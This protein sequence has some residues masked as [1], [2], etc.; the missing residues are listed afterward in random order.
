MK[1]YKF[2]EK[3]MAMQFDENNPKECALVKFG[4][5]DTPDGWY[6]ESVGRYMMSGVGVY[7]TKLHHGD[8]IVIR[9][10]ESANVYT[11]EEFLEKF[12]PCKND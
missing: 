6:I 2:R 1:R 5:D 4:F 9:E 10:N 3:V 8:W 7:K 12:K 11:N